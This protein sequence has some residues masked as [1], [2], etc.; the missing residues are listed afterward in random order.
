LFDA[1]DLDTVAALQTSIDRF[2]VLV[3]IAQDQQA[4]VLDGHH[5]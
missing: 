1:L 5:R 2:G 4:N 3:P